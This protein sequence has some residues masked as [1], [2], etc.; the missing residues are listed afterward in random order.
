M[1]W[2]AAK[3]YEEE[4]FETESELEAAINEAARAMFGSSRI[5]LDVKKKVGAKAGPRVRSLPVQ[6]PFSARDRRHRPPE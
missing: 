1:L 6:D 3:A 2:S 5:Y 4:P